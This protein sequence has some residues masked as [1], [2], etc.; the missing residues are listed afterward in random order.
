MIETVKQVDEGTYLINNSVKM[1]NIEMD[2]TEIVYDIDFDEKMV[3]EDESIKLCEEFL[4]KAVDEF[5]SNL[6][7]ER[8]AQAKAAQTA[9][10]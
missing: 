1:S 5:V 6:N 10:V 2:G 9:S 8:A 3:A 7:N 4:K